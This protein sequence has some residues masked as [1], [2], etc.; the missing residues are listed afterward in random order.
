MNEDFFVELLKKEL[1]P[2]LGCTEPIAIAFVSA[3]AKE[4]L[5]CFP[6]KVEI[7]VSGNVLKNVK[8]VKV[9]NTNGL[10][11]VESACVVGIVGGDATKNLEVLQ[12]V[13]QENVDVS[14]NLLANGFCKVTHLKSNEPLHIVVSVFKGSDKVSVELKNGHTNIVK[15]TKNDNIIYCSAKQET[16]N[17]ESRFLLKDVF[18][19]ANTVKI[20]KVF[21]IINNQIEY[22]SAICEEGIKNNYGQNIGKT[23]LSVYG[24]DFKV[25]AKALAAAGSDARMSGC[26]LPVVINSGS[27]NQGI[28]VSI[29][30]IE[31]AKHLNVGKE[32]L[33]RALIVSN[34][35]AIHLKQGIGKLSAYCGVVSASCGAG[36]GITYL[37]GGNFEQISKTI[38]NTIANISG[39]V[40][41]GAKGSCAA[42]IASSVD[43]CILAHFMTV[44]E[45]YFRAGDGIVKE[46]IED[47]IFGVSKIGKDA[48]KETDCEIL[49]IMFNEYK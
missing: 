17:C 38:T 5:G 40:C 25:R 28:A 9:P 47:T 46:N 13:T 36:A 3:K 19:F 7:A 6:D 42:K 21:D 43:A 18:D 23:L 31:F 45:N 49:N 44:G 2:A 15:I 22:N 35:V 27:G 37:Y 39:I 34:L 12:S 11:G 8:S 48:M 14:K 29:P 24:N 20:E 1:V 26:S 4:I 33:I 32:P 10:I 30:V 41:D 16:E